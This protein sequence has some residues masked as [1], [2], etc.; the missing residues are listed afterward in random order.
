MSTKTLGWQQVAN[1]TPTSPQ[2]LVVEDN[3]GLRKALNQ[4]LTE[5]GY[6]VRLAVSAEEADSWMSAM[7]FDI[8]LLDIGL[9]RMNGVEF[10]DWALK[11]DPELSVIML[12]GIDD[13]ETVAT[14][15]ESGA[16]T[17]LVKPLHPD[18]LRLIL[19]DALAVRSILVERNQL[20]NLSGAVEV[21]ED[22]YVARRA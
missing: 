22:A 10:L 1:Y 15:L 9:P 3:L 18:L 4:A 20:M 12:T 2:I 17:Y 14:C 6:Q 13:M 8:M 5:M 19:K 16:R 7:R 11:S 21:A